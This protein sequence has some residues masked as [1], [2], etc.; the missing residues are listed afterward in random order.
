MDN[1]ANNFYLTNVKLQRAP[2][3]SFNNRPF[4]QELALCQR[5]YEKS[6]PL[7]TFPGAATSLGSEFWSSNGHSNNGYT[8][9]KSAS[10]SVSKRANPTVVSYDTAGTAGKVYMTAEGVAATV[11]QESTRGFWVSGT[12]GAS[13]TRRFRF[14]WTSDAE[15]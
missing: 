15:L 14:H 1:T 5:Y 10:F 4:E 12:E 7:P 8:I 2:Y 6:Y 9:F 13:T 3:T 11:A